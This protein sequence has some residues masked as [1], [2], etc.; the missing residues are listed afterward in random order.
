VTTM[1][2]FFDDFEWSDIPKLLRNCW[3][4]LI[5][6]GVVLA[7]GIAITVIVIIISSTHTVPIG[8]YGLE[9]NRHTKKVRLD[10]VFTQGRHWNG[11]GRKFITFPSRQVT[12][13]ISSMDVRSNDG[14]TVTCDISYQLSFD[15]KTLTAMFANLGDEYKNTYTEVIKHTVR[16]IA[17]LYNA[18]DFYTNRV[19]IGNEISNITTTRVKDLY[20]V[21]GG[22]QL[23][24]V[25]LP[26]KY[27][28]FINAKT[29]ATQLLEQAKNDYQRAVTEADTKVIQASNAAQ[30]SILSALGESEGTLLGQS[31]AI[32]GNLQKILSSSKAYEQFATELQ[33]TDD[34]LLAYLWI[35]NIRNVANGGGQS[36]FINVDKP[37][38]L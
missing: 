15:Q 25:T 26:S 20:A 24:S 38:N 6:I 32:E 22:F 7:I 16:D 18:T 13:T 36:R 14:I 17:S 33:L 19:D 10:K 8:E 30:V 31:K 21:L 23:K 34:E 11:P 12:Y 2:D 3:S 37:K 28:Y 5:G 4:A 29:T 35:D 27:D 1:M 9:Y